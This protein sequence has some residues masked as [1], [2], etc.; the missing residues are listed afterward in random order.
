MVDAHMEK[1]R[2]FIS[3]LI[4]NFWFRFLELICTVRDTN[5]MLKHQSSKIKFIFGD[6]NITKP[7][8]S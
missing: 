7:E 5:Q 3:D 2:V 6:L 8:L 4:N 1:R